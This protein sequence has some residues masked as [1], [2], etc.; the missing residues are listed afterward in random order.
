MVGATFNLFN[1]SITCDVCIWNFKRI[2]L[3]TILPFLYHDNPLTKINVIYCFSQI[4]PVRESMMEA[5]QLWKKIAGKGDGS[6]S[7]GRPWI[8]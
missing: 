4:K 6:S 3:G 7:H 1:C 5:L 2:K 8:K